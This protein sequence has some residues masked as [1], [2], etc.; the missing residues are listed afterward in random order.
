MKGNISPYRTLM[1]MASRQG[2]VDDILMPM[3]EE[4]IAVNVGAETP[5]DLFRGVR[6][7]VFS[8]DVSDKKVRT[9]WFWCA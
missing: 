2:M 7:S 9:D 4:E 8:I 3:L 1:H 5:G 6:T